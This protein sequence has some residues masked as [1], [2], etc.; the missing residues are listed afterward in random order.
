MDSIKIFI[1]HYKKLVE[2]R[3]FMIRQFE[4]LGIT[5]YEFIDQ[6]D[7]NSLNSDE[8]TIFSPDFK[9]LYYRLK[10]SHSASLGIDEEARSQV[11]VN[12]QMAIT[13]SHIYA[14]RE[15]VNKYDCALILEDDAVLH[16]NFCELFL[17]YVSQ[18]PNNYSMMYIGNGCNLHIENHKLIDNCNLYE[19]PNTRCTDSYLVSKDCA[20]RMINYID[21]LNHVVNEPVDWWLNHVIRDLQLLVFWSEP[22]IVTQGTQNGMFQPSY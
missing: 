1:I 10:R 9:Q 19:K 8:L 6:Y 2:R 16:P 5:N 14:Y 15:I 21:N 18:L 3:E 4:K 22:T 17:N 20:R 11:W 13:L 12:G 7:R